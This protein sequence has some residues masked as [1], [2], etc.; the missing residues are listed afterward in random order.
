MLLGTH[1]HR[2]CSAGSYPGIQFFGEPILE[3]GITWRGATIQSPTTGVCVT[4]PEHS[5]GKDETVDLLIHPCFSGPFELPAG[6]KSA[7]PA[8]L[9]H[10]SR[11]V[12][13]LKPVTIQ[14]HHYTSLL[15]EEDCEEMDFFSSPP[16]PRYRNDIPVYTFRHARKC[17]GKFRTKSQMGEIQLK[18]FCVIKI[19]RKKR[20]KKKQNG[21]K[22]AIYRFCTKFHFRPAQATTHYTPPDCTAVC[23]MAP[24]QH[25]QCSVRACATHSTSGYVL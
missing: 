21:E 15:N 7:S 12:S 18:H 3:E 6:Y 23:P 10:P 8:Y 5:L 1:F 25:Q 17:K 14:I 20:S 22:G 24:Q 11:K 16:T 9:I 2:Y 19:G 13:F 4:I